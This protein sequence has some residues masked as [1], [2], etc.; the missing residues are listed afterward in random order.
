[1]KAFRTGGTVIPGGGVYVEREQDLVFRREVLKSAAWINVFG[2]R[3]MGK[4]SLCA[5]YQGFLHDQSVIPLFVDAASQIG[6]VK[7]AIDWV[8]G[9]AKA[10]ESAMRIQSIQS[11]LS[12][13]LQSYH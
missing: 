1:M 12:L 2:C 6:V 13:D 11:G 9:L 3:T 7:E 5:Q 10:I 4:S 8:K